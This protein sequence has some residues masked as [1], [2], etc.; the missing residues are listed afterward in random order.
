MTLHR[1]A[2]VLTDRHALTIIDRFNRLDSMDF[3]PK[4]ISDIFNLSRT[5]KIS[6]SARSAS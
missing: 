5:K 3:M 6:T 1:S 4:I 2:V